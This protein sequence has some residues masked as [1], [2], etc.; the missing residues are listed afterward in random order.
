MLPLGVSF[1]HLLNFD[2]PIRA[3]ARL[4]LSNFDLNMVVSRLVW[5]DETKEGQTT[6]FTSKI[7]NQQ[8]HRMEEAKNV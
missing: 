6:Q 3:A 1:A 4:I 2:L 8:G 5:V 7:T